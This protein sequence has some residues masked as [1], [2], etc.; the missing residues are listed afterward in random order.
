MTCSDCCNGLI[1]LV[2]CSVPRYYV[3]NPATKQCI[4][5][6]RAREHVAPYHAALA[7]NPSESSQFEVIRFICVLSYSASKPPAVNVFSSETGMFYELSFSKHLLCFDIKALTA[8]AIDIPD[9]DKF[10]K[11]GFIG[12]LQCQ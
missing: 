7:F 2:R 5:V 9:K 6:P 11:Y 1:L 3:C 10:D 4:A 12:A 8:Q